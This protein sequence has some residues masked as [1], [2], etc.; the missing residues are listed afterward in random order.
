MKRSEKEV[1]VEELTDIF[2]KSK[3]IYMTDF[4]GLN[5][6]EMTELRSKLR[7]MSAS[8][9]VVKNTLALLAMERAGLKDLGGLIDGAV[10]LAFT[11]EDEIAPAKVIV[12]FSKKRD[13]P[14]VKSGI[15]DGKVIGPEDIV[16]L[17]N[18]PSREQLL[19]MV[20]GGIGAPLNS[21]LQCLNGIMRNL[22]Y[23]LNSLSEK[24]K[25]EEGMDG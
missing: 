14:K 9:K 1:V 18:L 2:S 5:V 24:R 19:A 4:T 10:G 22:L 12:E 16:Q 6:E 8:Y 21:F 7:D 3:V 23:A 15:I 17:A 20:S 11:D 25:E 13:K